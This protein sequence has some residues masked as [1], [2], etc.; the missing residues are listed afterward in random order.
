MEN[1]T[2]VSEIV[3]G[4]VIDQKYS[5]NAIEPHL[6]IKPY[7]DILQYIQKN[8]NWEIEDLI[9]KFGIT[10]V[11]TAKM[12]LQSLNGLGEKTN[13]GKLLRK[14]Y[15]MHT[16]GG[17]VESSGKKLQR[18]IE[19]DVPRIISSLSNL[20]TNSGDLIKAS[21]VIPSEVGLV[22]TGWKTIDYHLGGLPEVGLVTVVAPPKIGKTSWLCRLIG[23]YLRKY[24]EKT[25]VAVT[26]EMI[27][28]QFMKRFYEINPDV[29]KQE[30][31][32]L[33][34]IHNVR[35]AAEAAAK[36]STVTNVGLVGID[37]ADL[38][39]RGMVDSSQME[40][41]YR[42]CQNLAMD[43]RIP[44]V[45][46]S[47]VSRTYQGGLV[48]PFHA[49]W[50]AMAEALSWMMLT[51]YS[52]ARDY[53]PKSQ[54]SEGLPTDYGQS[55]IIAWLCRSKTNS[56]LPGAI[57]I[58]WVGETGWCANSKGTWHSLNKA[59]KMIKKEDNEED[60]TF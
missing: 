58:P 42:V 56:E 30:L 8:D 46:L 18:G 39:I 27:E 49:R 15:D 6:L 2:D 52:P 55:Y 1:W 45:L 44:V 40:E 33:I 14:S 5:P 13:W 20:T 54:G 48:R 22:E 60:W 36:A 9:G 43:M 16:V 17:M 10:P 32:R 51:L 12:A 31:E 35:S 47:Q 19:I 28:T 37:F 24:P 57:Q 21:E 7:S 25:V 38:L 11:N 29:T 41:V 34:L 53:F 23:Q 3:T 50:T 59:E 4:M 26:R